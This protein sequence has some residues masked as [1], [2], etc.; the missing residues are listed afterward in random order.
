VF[1]NSYELA[2]GQ[3]L[4]FVKALE[5]VSINTVLPVDRAKDISLATLPGTVREGGFGTPQ[6]LKLP[7][8]GV[9]TE[10]V[11]AFYEN[12]HWLGRLNAGHYYILTPSKSNNIGSTLIYMRAGW[13]SVP[14]NATLKVGDNLFLDTNREWRYMFRIDQVNT[15]SYTDKYV[16]EDSVLPKLTVVIEDEQNQVN[17][18][19]SASFVNIQNVQK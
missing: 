9:K 16:L 18:I 2:F 11:P 6:A 15:Y 1:A 3:D 7:S 5:P 13:R 17:H 14:S 8:L 10:L 4:P 19:I 12:N